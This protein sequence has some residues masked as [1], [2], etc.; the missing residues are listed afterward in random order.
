MAIRRPDYPGGTASKK[1]VCGWCGTVHRSY[2]DSKTRLVRDL[3]CGDARIYLDVG[4]Q[5]V[6]CRRGGKVKRERLDWLAD[7]P[8]YPK[9]FALFVGRRCRSM[10]IKDVAKEVHLDW[11]TVKGLEKQY[12]A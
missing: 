4:G 11:H 2:S 3:S 12:M 7:N 1:T 6:S 5:R 10:S 9:R 8:F